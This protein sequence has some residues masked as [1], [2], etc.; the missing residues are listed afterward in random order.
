MPPLFIVARDMVR[1]F[2]Y[3]NDSHLHFLFEIDSN[4]NVCSDPAE[5]YV[6]CFTRLTH[7]TQ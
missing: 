5:Q 4:Q 3:N 7:D 1:H 6:H 2:I